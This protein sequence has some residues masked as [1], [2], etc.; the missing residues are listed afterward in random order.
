MK[1]NT[2][3]VLLAATVSGAVIGAQNQTLTVKDLT[4][5]ASKVEHDPNAVNALLGKTFRLVLIKTSKTHLFEIAGDLGLTAICPPAERF[6]GG[7]ITAKL[8]SFEL[9]VDLGGLDGNVVKLD[10]CN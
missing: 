5:A 2:L 9:D 1:I 8:V 7:V 4:A 3:L 6:E 10:S